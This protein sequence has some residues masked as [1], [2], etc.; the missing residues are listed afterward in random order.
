MSP[1]FLSPSSNV[2]S[3]TPFGN[4]RVRGTAPQQPGP[5]PSRATATASGLKD[6]LRVYGGERLGLEAACRRALRTGTLTYGSV[7]SILATGLD[8][9]DD[10]QSR[11]LT[12]PACVFRRSRPP[13]P[14]QGPPG[15]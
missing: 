7:K 5:T 3:S 1:S 14:S 2:A 4:G 6:L 10:E 15:G 11:T 8:R 12:C 9:A 13:V